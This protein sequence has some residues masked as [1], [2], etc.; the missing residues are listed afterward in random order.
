MAQAAVD[1]LAGVFKTVIGVMKDCVYSS[2]SARKPR[3]RVAQMC[4]CTDIGIWS[5]VKSKPDKL[6]NITVVKGVV[7][8]LRHVVDC[9]ASDMFG[10]V[11]ECLNAR[12]APRKTITQKLEK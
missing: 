3:A 10:V 2:T 1:L 9:V 7:A 8:V 11:E 5:D 12:S 6:E 4:F